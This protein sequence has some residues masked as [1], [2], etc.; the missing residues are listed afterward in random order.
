M[1][2]YTHYYSNGKE[3]RWRTLLQIGDSW[4]ICGTIFMKNP[5]SS[6]NKCTNKKSIDDESLLECLREFDDKKTLSSYD[7]FEFSIDKTMACIKE[8]FEIYYQAEQKTLNGVIQIFNLFNI[9]DANL[10]KAISKSKVDIIDELA[11][12]TD[13]DVKHIVPPVYIGWGDLWKM[14]IHRKNAEMVFS[15]VLKMTTHYSDGIQ[16][17]KYYHPLYLMLYGKNKCNCK[18]ELTR[19]IKGVL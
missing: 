16:N 19:F 5:G 10:G 4:E 6:I 17:N 18:K 11:F 7:W 2:V 1:K 3:Y 9:R 12:T 13:Y 8:L 15:E 14:P